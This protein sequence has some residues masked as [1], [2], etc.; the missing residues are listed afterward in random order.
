M[1]LLMPSQEDFIPC[2]ARPACPICGSDMIHA[3]IEEGKTTAYHVWICDCEAQ[4]DGIREEIIIGR[5]YEPYTALII[6]SE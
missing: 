6:Y 5:D 4:P 3:R 2:Y 1:T